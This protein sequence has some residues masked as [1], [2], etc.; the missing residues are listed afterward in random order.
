MIY[1]FIAALMIAATALWR[2]D[3]TAKLETAA[4]LAGAP[5]V[6][7]VF[8][9]MLTAV[10]D[11][12]LDGYFQRIDLLLGWNGGGFVLDVRSVP[13]LY[14]ILHAVYLTL[15][16]A[17]AAAWLATDR[18]H[19]M[20]T[21]FLLAAFVGVGLYFIFPAVGPTYAFPHGADAPFDL[22]QV[23]STAPRN[24]MPSL[25]LSW[26]LIALGYSTRWPARVLLTVFA[27]LTGLATIG[28][29]EHYV[30]DLLACVPFCLA[31]E[32]VA[33]HWAGAQSA[34][35]ASNRTAWCPSAGIS[36]VH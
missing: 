19:E 18:R 30:I 12:T 22:V 29:G 2:D 23:A 25:H 14:T 5:I 36:V 20:R 24:C 11:W 28:L 7:A 15:P 8:H 9:L 34:A 16:I 35:L 21:A 31:V 26:A 10:T 1:C 27:V 32:C 6:L 13:V 3:R 4:I 17:L 33:V